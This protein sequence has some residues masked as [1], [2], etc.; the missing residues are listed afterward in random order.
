MKWIVRESENRLMGDPFFY[1][2]HSLL[3]AYRVLSSFSIHGLEVSHTTIYP[4]HIS[5]HKLHLHTVVRKKR[6][7]N[8]NFDIG[9]LFRREK[10]F[11]KVG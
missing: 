1:I 8:N 3:L 9:V 10:F 11:E 7:F 5:L 4:T 6:Q 2:S